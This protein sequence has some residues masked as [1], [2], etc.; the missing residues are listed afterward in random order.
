MPRT[1]EMKPFS[2][3][4]KI[5]W[6]TEIE[7]FPQC[8]ISPQNW[9]FSQT[10]SPWLYLI[11]KQLLASNLPQAPSNLICFPILGTLNLS[12]CFNLKLEQL[13]CK[14]VLKFVSLDNCTSDLFTE[15]Q[16]WY[17]KSFKFGL[18]R[19]FRKII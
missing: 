9:S 19:F 14:K 3:L 4:A 10:F 13:I 5:S 7:I 15:V 1:P 8:P 11:W 18:G 17:W 2:M 12:W 16:I 6:K